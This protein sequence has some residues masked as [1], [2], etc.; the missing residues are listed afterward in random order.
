M[1][2]IENIQDFSFLLLAILSIGSSLGVIFLPNLVY[3]AF[4]LG[5]V[6]LAVAGL[7]LLLNADFLA[8]AQVLLYVGGVNILILFAIMLIQGNSATL[9]QG[10]TSG[11]WSNPL[12][13]GLCFGLFLLIYQVIDGTPWLTPPFFGV[14]DSTSLIGRHIFSDF[15]LPFELI[16]V[17]LL[18]ALI[19]AVILAKK[20]QLPK[21]QNRF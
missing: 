6:L 13:G 19:G 20:E 12:K 5:A 18:V 15:L 9:P 21:S 14:T 1:N 7:Y 4:L 2:I 10:T 11:G 17:L 16:S 3:S 8:A